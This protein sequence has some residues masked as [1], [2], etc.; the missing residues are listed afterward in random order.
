MLNK[1]PYRGLDVVDAIDTTCTYSF[2]ND[3]IF[4]S[5]MPQNLRDETIKRLEIM[6][7]NAYVR[8][9]N[10]LLSVGKGEWNPERVCLK[11]SG[12]PLNGRIRVTKNMDIIY[13]NGTIVGGITYWI[14]SEKVKKYSETIG[15]YYRFIQDFDSQGLQLKEQRFLMGKLNGLQVSWDNER[16]FLRSYYESG[17]L[18]YEESFRADGSLAWRTKYNYD[19]EI[20]EEYFFEG[21][22]EMSSKYI[23]EFKYGIKGILIESWSKK[24]DAPND[25]LPF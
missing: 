9:V 11:S 4:N 24:G 15:G 16:R 6:V 5:Y 14:N 22:G 19:K 2:F 18:N 20:V 21:N 10:H 13:K 12:D 8:F 23:H 1:Y 17:V 7:E 25:D 3:D